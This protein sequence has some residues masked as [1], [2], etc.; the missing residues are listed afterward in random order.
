M[1]PNVQKL[2]RIVVSLVAFSAIQSQ[3][4]AGGHTWRIKE[5]Y[6]NASGTVQFIE[7]VETCGTPGEIATAGHQVTANANSVNITA[8][9]PP[10]TSANKHLL[11]GTANLTSFGG[12]TPDYIIPANFISLTGVTVGYSGLHSCVIGSGA[13]PT[14]GTSS[15]NRATACGGATCPTT[16]A[17][18]SPTNLAGASSPVNAPA[19]MDVD[20]DGYGSPGDAACPNGAATDCN[21]GNNA[22]NPGATENCTDT[23]DNDC[24]LNAD[25][26]DSGCTANPACSVPT[27]SQWG[28]VVMA[29]L[30]LIAGTLLTKQKRAP[31]V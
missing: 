30:L 1:T 23:I 31:S 26:L 21:D 4:I 3:V 29:T 18:N 10:G 13:I 8:N 22:I 25:C 6:S 11:F 2:G 14:N 24:D 20:G 19:C 27:V 7:A 28:V 16:T 17:L 9:L 5:V 15:L 12:P